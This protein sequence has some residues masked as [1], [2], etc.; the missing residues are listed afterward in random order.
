MYNY[1]STKPD[2]GSNIVKSFITVM[3]FNDTKMMSNLKI[4]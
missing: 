1:I 2:E 4:Y 3:I